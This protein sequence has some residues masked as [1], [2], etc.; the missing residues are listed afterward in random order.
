MS[1]LPSALRIYL[2]TVWGASFIV[3]SIC[4]YLQ[5]SWASTLPATG[6]FALLAV[7]TELK[8]TIYD[9]VYW[10]TVVTAILLC[11]AFVLPPFS[12]VV[13]ALIGVL[14]AEVLYKKPWYKSCFN[15]ASSAIFFGLPAIYINIFNVDPALVNIRNIIH[16]LTAF[17]VYILL[18]TSLIGI[19]VTLA[20]GGKVASV[21][22]ALPKFF[23]A[24]DVAL[25]PYGL[26][27]AWLWNLG[28][29]QFV[30]GLLPLIALQRLFATHAGLIHEQA[31]TARLVEQQRRVQE[32]M[33]TL[34]STK[35]IRTQLHTLLEHITGFFPVSQASVILWGGLDEADQ[36]FTH[37]NPG[38][39]LPLDKWRDQLKRYSHERRLMR[40]GD[41]VLME[42]CGCQSV[43][44]V[45]L[46]TSEDAVGCLLLLEQ[47]ASA[48]DQQEEHLIETFA[49]EAA[50]AIYQA[51]LIAQLKESQVRLM[52]SARLATVGTL[53]AGIAHDFN[54]LLGAIGGNAQLGLMEPDPGEHLLMFKEIANTTRKGANI[55]HGLLAFA[56]Q[57][58]SQRELAD[59]REAI[60]PVLTMLQAE[61]RRK[62]IQVVREFESVPQIEC[63]IGMLLQ[64]VMN[65]V[66]NAIDAMQAKGGTLTIRL[67]QQDDRLRLAV[68]DTGSGIPQ[69]VR[70]HM[71]D[72]F[73]TSKTGDTSHLHGGTGIGLTMTQTIV[74]NHGG[75]IEVESELGVGTTIT[76]FLPIPSYSSQE[77]PP[78]VKVN[79]G[80]KLHAIVVDDEPKVAET[81][82]SILTLQGHTAEWFTE[83]LEA[84]K[85][86][87]HTPVDI[88]FADLRMPNM[89]GLTLLQ[90]VRQCIPSAI[91]VLITGYIDAYEV[92]EAKQLGATAV[93]PKPFSY[94]QIRRFVDDLRVSAV[95]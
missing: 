60:E 68:S 34:L 87:E 92:E 20:G 67:D 36:T 39:T 29:W 8:P 55:A 40:L 77:L 61:F 75:S 71:F 83:P 80:P 21:W 76:V 93:I 6:V 18:S 78:A 14:V 33:T 85:A 30:V 15:A 79:A 25:L 2:L 13:V 32:T 88:V 51:R 17:F 54:N 37:G 28:P 70:E 89:D 50:L 9:K 57:Q 59:V 62:N 22:R 58:Q 86:I 84:L 63:D 7:A 4:F 3:L 24:Y 45:P 72:A 1:N 49:A 27:L 48:L 94:G 10:Q 26:I 38:F 46:R 16:I 42:E 90:K 53:A 52:E 19:V 91:R 23:N 82:S 64:V 44:F 73:F 66:T 65:L 47:Q 43:L 35:D 41:D 5:S 31:I 12:V 69:D 81:L 56:R 74:K 11:A 95:H